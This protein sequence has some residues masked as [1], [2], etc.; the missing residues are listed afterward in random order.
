MVYLV[1]YIVAGGVLQWA[2]P[3]MRIA[4][5]LHDWQVFSLYGLFLV[6]LSILVRGRPWHTQYVYAVAAIGPID[7]IGFAIGTSIA[8][9]G[10]VIERV[11]GTRSFT[12]AFVLAAGWI[13]VVGNIVVS[14]LEALLFERREVPR[15]R[16]RVYRTE[17]FHLPSLETR[18]ADNEKSLPAA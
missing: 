12:L 14:R 15:G 13:P 7:V 2:S 5:F 10:N 3:Y 18:A 16:H 11:V 8:Y 17:D 1:V 4:A 6:P 9:P